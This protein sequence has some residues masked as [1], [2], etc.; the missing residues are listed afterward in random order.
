MEEFFPVKNR[1]NALKHVQ[2]IVVVHYNDGTPVLRC[3][4]WNQN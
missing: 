2:T 4:R 3:F 1:D